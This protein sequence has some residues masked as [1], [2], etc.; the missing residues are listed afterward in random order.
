MIMM[1]LI[2]GLVY[3][4]S[5]LLMNIRLW[6]QDFWPE[7]GEY[8]ILYRLLCVIFDFILWPCSLCSDIVRTIIMLRLM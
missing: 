7:Y 8:N 2:I 5:T 1:Y 4:V 6:K 3:S